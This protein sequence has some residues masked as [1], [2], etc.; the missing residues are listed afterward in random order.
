MGS[1]EVITEWTKHDRNEDE[2]AAQHCSI[3]G[4]RE[5]QKRTYDLRDFEDQL[6]DS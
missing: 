4:V 5:W 6:E 1:P 3:L 2:S